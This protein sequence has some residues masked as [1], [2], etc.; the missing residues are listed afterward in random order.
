M[1]TRL[2]QLHKRFQY[3]F[4]GLMEPFEERQGIEDFRRRL[5]MQHAISN[6]SGKI[7]AFI[8]GIMEYEVIRDEDQMLNLK[9]Q[10]QGMDIEVLI[11]VVY[12]KCTQK[13]DIT[14]VGIYG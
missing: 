12:A 13:G 8:D 11:S 14:I 7:W 4:V 5:G 6:S 3:Y 9:I 10:N 1:F 2:I